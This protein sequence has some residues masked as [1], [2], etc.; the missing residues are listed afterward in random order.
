MIITGPGLTPGRSLIQS[1]IEKHEGK[2]QVHSEL[3]KGS[4]FDIWLPAA[5][6]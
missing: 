5:H 2:I 3:R 4:Q 6:I 1:F